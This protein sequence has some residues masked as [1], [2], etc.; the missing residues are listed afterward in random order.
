MILPVRYTQLLVLLMATSLPYAA[1]A[2]G[3][4]G[5]LEP[6]RTIEVSSQ[7][8]GIV[9]SVLVERGDRVEV[10]QVLVELKSGLERVAVSRARARLEFAIRR[11]ARNAALFEKELISPNDRDEIET[12]VQLARLQLR[13][14][15]EH[16]AMRTI[17]S[18]ISGVVVARSRS[19]GEFVGQDPVLTVASIDPL[20]VELIV[21]VAR[22]GSVKVGTFAEVM[23]EAPVGG[24]HRARVTIVDE[25]IDAASG[26]FGVRMELPNPNY[27]VP[28]GLKCKVRFAAD[29][30]SGGS[31]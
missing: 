17:R 9:D 13:E 18:P 19:R 30:D 20:S 23:P 11:M 24:I 1:S 15:E 5:L 3:Y 12:E 7:V 21:P 22:Y 31:E 14:V 4:D 10:G 25:V 28:A 8:S 29:S 27:E 16:L 6:N 2:V 26:T